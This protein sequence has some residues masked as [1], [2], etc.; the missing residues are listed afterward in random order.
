M[1]WWQKPGTRE[2][3]NPIQA[4]GKP[5]WDKAPFLHMKPTHKNQNQVLE[6]RKVMQDHLQ[7]GAVKRL[8]E[9]T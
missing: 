8:S 5:I 3:I 2:V 4:G 9:Q 7:A 1:P 6:D